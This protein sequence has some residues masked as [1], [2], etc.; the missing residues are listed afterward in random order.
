MITNISKTTMTLSSLYPA[1]FLKTSDIPDDGDLVLTIS[2]LEIEEIGIE[3][4][5]KPVVYFAETDKGLV[6]NKTNAMT[7][8]DIFGQQITDWIDKRI[9]LF[10]TEVTYNGKTQLGIRI[11]VRPPQAKKYPPQA[12]AGSFPKEEAD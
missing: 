11:R 1:K 8:G 12:D 4:E 10:T 3:K 6:L 9:A 5:E 2:R 7:I